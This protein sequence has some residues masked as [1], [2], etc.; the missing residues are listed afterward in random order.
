M[1]LHITLELPIVD[2]QFHSNNAVQDNYSLPLSVG[3]LSIAVDYHLMN[4][5]LHSLFSF[6]LNSQSQK[7]TT[8]HSQGKR[9][10]REQRGRSGTEE[11]WKTGGR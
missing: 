2:V 6:P 11:D 8:A 10:K 9:G 5:I 7:D 3:S 4:G 1:K